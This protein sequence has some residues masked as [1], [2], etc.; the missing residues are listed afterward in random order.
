MDNF[1]QWA[2][3]KFCL[4]LGKSNG[5]MKMILPVLWQ[6]SDLVLPSSP[7][8]SSLSLCV[9]LTSVCEW[10][11]PESLSLRG[12]TR[13]QVSFEEWV[14]GSH[15]W[16]LTDVWTVI[17][18]LVGVCRFWRAVIWKQL[19]LIGANKGTSLIET[20]RFVFCFAEWQWTVPWLTGQTIGVNTQ[21]FLCNTWFYFLI[22]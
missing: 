11:L 12:C 20:L 7:Y 9:I 15:A 5:N 4:S 17:W 18:M 13:G 21:R 19:C 1:R 8:F 14:T 3:I 2:S 16:W 10:R 22:S 6:T